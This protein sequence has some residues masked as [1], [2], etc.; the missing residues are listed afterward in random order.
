MTRV[1]S[2]RLVSKILGGLLLAAAVLKLQGLGTDPVTR[3]GVFSTPEFQLFVVEFEVFLGV[4]LLS[5]K[6]P[7]GSWLLALTTFGLFAAVS[8]YQGWI[9][10]ASCGC[11]GRLRVN[12]WYA[13]GLDMVIVAT[14]LVGRPD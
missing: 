14:L 13:F 2:Y 4:W 3:L 5:G 7:L 1:L 12:P 10:Q 8:F 9:G 6:R 11:F